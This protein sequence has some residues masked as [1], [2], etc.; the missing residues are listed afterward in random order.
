M[1]PIARHVTTT[2]GR[3][4]TRYLA[5]DA[6]SVVGYCKLSAAGGY[7]ITRD[8]RNNGNFHETV[9][10]RS[11]CLLFLRSRTGQLLQAGGRVAFLLIRHLSNDVHSVI[12]LT[13]TWK[14]AE[15][16]RHPVLRFEAGAP[17]RRPVCC[18][19]LFSLL[20][21]AVSSEIGLNLGYL[22]PEGGGGCVN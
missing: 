13:Q 21:A 22:D 1:H 14:A 16:K 11:V 5:A 4:V 12:G 18:S 20:T 8:R 7:W 9:R 15:V 10:R 3:R 2:R 19:P 17:G 6:E